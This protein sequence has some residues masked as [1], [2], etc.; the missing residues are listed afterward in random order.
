VNQRV[1]PGLAYVGID[2]KVV[3]GVESR[4]RMM[5]FVPAHTHKI[6]ERIGILG[7]LLSIAL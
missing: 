1:Y 4:A 3:G 6:F 2:L 5:T 7:N